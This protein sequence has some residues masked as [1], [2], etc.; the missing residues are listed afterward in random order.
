MRVHEGEVFLTRLAI[1]F[2]CFARLFTVWGNSPDPAIVR[3]IVKILE[4][5]G[6]SYVP[7]DA[8]G[9]AYD[10]RNRHKASIRTWYA[11]YF[12]YV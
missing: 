7:M 9:E 8:L 6:F 12:D 2:S 11:R 5:D 10:G 4:T 1:P 3:A